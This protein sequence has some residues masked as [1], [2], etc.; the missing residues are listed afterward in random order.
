MRKEWKSPRMVGLDDD[1]WL[2]IARSIQRN[3]I[4]KKMNE[5]YVL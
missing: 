2:T 4:I 5:K 1:S 3:S